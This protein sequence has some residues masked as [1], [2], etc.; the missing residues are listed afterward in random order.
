MRRAELVRAVR[1][2]LHALRDSRVHEALAEVARGARGEQASFALLSALRGYTVRAAEFGPEE[3][4]VLQAMDLQALDDPAWWA[5]VVGGGA[6]GGPQ[7]EAAAAMATSIR[8]AGTYLPR[9]AG[10]LSTEALRRGAAAARQPPP[11]SEDGL[12]LLEVLVIETE[13]Q[14]S[15]PM[16]LITA[17]ESVWLLYDAAATLLRLPSNTLGVAGCDSG[18][19]KSFEFLGLAPV[20]ASVKEILLSVWDRVVFYRGRPSEA[21]VEMIERS[22]PVLNRIARMREAGEIGPEQAELL[23]RGIVAGVKKFLDAGC[24]IPEIEASASHEARDLLAPSPKL[25]ASG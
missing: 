6:E 14:R 22:V 25:L 9:L 13:G 21:R 5:R 1:S 19:D 17:L 10:L 18:S 24:T 23:R 15:S 12:E 2:V 4:R 11:P 7:A 16:R 3:R 8:S 20:V